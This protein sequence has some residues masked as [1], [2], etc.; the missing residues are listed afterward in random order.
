M[1]RLTDSAGIEDSVQRGLGIFLQQAI[2]QYR[3]VGT[4]VHCL[5]SM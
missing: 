3:K 4:A 5:Q 2:W 1:L